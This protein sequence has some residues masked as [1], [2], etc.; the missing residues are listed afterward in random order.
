MNS[1]YGMYTF[2]KKLKG[3]F[4]FP[5]QTCMHLNV[6]YMHISFS[7]MDE[8]LKDWSIKALRIFIIR[9]NTKDTKISAFNHL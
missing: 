9:M 6:K 2:K 7:T 1:M 4:M 3:A 5:W 8:L